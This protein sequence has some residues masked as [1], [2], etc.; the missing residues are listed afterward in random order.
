VEA[1]KK[2]PLEVN[3][4]HTMD[5]LSE[6]HERIA[7]LHRESEQRV[8]YF[9]AKVKN[10]VTSENA[11]ISK[12]NA[13]LQSEANAINE[14]IMDTYRS[15]RMKWS[16]DSKKASMEF[17]ASRQRETERIAALRIE[18]DTRFKATVDSFLSKMN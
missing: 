15:A 11:R 18:V 14:G 16:D 12:E 3:I 13:D 7:M 10:L 4:H 2:T 1:G 6:V 9:K 17:E 8:N 5:Q